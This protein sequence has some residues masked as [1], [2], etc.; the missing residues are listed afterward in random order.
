MVGRKVIDIPAARLLNCK[1]L[2]RQQRCAD[3]QEKALL[4]YGR[5]DGISVETDPLEVGRR[6]RSSRAPIDRT[7]GSANCHLPGV[8]EMAAV[9]VKNILPLASP[10]RDPIVRW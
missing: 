3:H 4:C 8:T 6:R 5:H 9:C 1:H 7:F 10:M 2:I